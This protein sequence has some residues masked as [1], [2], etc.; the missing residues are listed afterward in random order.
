MSVAVE[1]A[2]DG[3]AMFDKLKTVLVVIPGVM[4]LMVSRMGLMVS[5]NIGLVGWWVGWFS[6]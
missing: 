3:L 4:G 1:V 6:G 2:R 5:R